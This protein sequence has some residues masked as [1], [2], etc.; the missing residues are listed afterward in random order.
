MLR[1]YHYDV[2]ELVEP[3]VL[4]PMGPLVR[5][6]TDAKGEIDRVLIPV[7]PALPG[8]EFKKVR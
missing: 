4:M 6:L 3:N 7:E 8:I 5:F 2:F 1:H